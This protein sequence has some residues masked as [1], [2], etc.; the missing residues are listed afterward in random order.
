[1]SNN[2]GTG[3]WVV[4]ALIAAMSVAALVEAAYGLAATI[5]RRCLR[6][7]ALGL[8]FRAL[9]SDRKSA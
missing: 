9:I 6:S 7:A 5:V 2:K 3:F 8:R 1:M 4:V